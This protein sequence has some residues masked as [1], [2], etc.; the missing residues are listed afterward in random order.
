LSF[1]ILSGKFIMPT[2]DD[3]LSP[4]PAPSSGQQAK[5]A[6]TAAAAPAAAQQEEPP[7]IHLPPPR[8]PRP[9]DSEQ[10]A[11]R[12]LRLDSILVALTLLLAFLLASFPARNSDVWAHLA[13]GR[14]LVQDGFAFGS[15]PFLF[16]T[17]GQ[18]W[19][20]HSWLYD[21]LSYGIYQLLGGSGLVI[22]K[23]LLVV[24]VAELMLRLGRVGRNL[25]AP[26]VCTAVALV[27]MSPGLHLQPICVSYLGLALTVWFLDRQ[28][29]RLVPEDRTAAP[30]GAFASY[31]PLLVLFVLWVNLDVWFF[32][33]P[34]AV[35]LYWL[36]EALETRTSN[37]EVHRRHLRLLGLVLLAGLGVC[38]LNPYHV[39]GFNLIPLLAPAPELAQDP[40]FRG[41]LISPFGALSL[42]PTSLA[43]LLLVGLGAGS[44]ALAGRQVRGWRLALWLGFFL[45]SVYQAR[46]VPFFAIVAGPILALHLQEY[47]ARR[48]TMVRPARVYRWALAGRRLTVA[49]GLVLLL[50]AWQGLVQ[51]RSLPLWRWVVEPD[52]ALP[53]AADQL[54]QWRG[55]GRLAAD[56]EGFNFS[57]DV[58]NYF[59]WAAPQK[60]FADGRLAD[61]P[62]VA[63][64]HAAIRQGVEEE[65]RRRREGRG[66]DLASPDWR[67]ILR[68]HKVNHIIL[69]DPDVNR[70]NAQ[71]E[72]FLTYPAEWPLLHL[73]GHTA[74]FGWRDPARRERD[75]FVGLRF[76]LQAAAFHPTAKKKAPSH[77]P[78]RPPEVRAWWDL[79]HSP[80]PPRP[81]DTD[82]AAIY[83]QYFETLVP[84]QRINQL[85]T[86]ASCMPVGLVG[87]TDP[88]VNWTAGIL[89][90]LGQEGAARSVLHFPRPKE[91]PGR[92]DQFA[93]EWQAGFLYSQDEAPLGLPLLAVRAA[94]RGVAASPDDANNYLVLAHA[95]RRLAR[96]RERSWAQRGCPRLGELRKVQV[97]TA[98]HNVLAANPTPLQAAQAHE[99]L[100]AIN[101]Q[102]N[103]QDVALKHGQERIRHFRAAGVIPGIPPQQFEKGMAR[104]E[105]ELKEF[106][107]DVR[108]LQDEY[109]AN[110]GKLR[111]LDQARLARN[112]GLAGKALEVL[113]ASDITSFGAEGAQLQLELMLT[114]G[115]ARDAGELLLPDL[116]ERLTAYP[117]HWI[118]VQVAAAAGDYAAADRELWVVQKIFNEVPQP[119]GAP[120][121]LRA[122]FG[123][124]LAAMT[125]DGPLPVARALRRQELVLLVHA[126]RAEAEVRVLRGLLALEWGET[127]QAAEHFRAALS[128]WGDVAGQPSPSGLEFSARWVAQ[129]CLALLR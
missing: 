80:A 65:L 107:K 22:L 106:E 66:P 69:L 16:T 123:A 128:V 58:G 24:L 27:A 23:A 77:G 85:F 114:T 72:Y 118:R 8:A 11:R 3:A 34:L 117:Y 89:G 76:D 101:R 86:W 108:E 91:R 36:G 59:A 90:R 20:N 25:W 40:Y 116:K 39:R 81:L 33:G 125:L 78:S 49:A 9:L 126:L 67:E 51:A 18:T 124:V 21:L 46:A 127:E 111:P 4:P 110:V 95:Y 31:W 52:P 5:T 57:P 19:V 103:Y 1:P 50:A 99:Y 121:P 44:F 73:D 48:S 64:E 10:A 120:R 129:D 63:K 102:I 75:P 88:R 104:L 92:L 14:A 113:L 38:L 37:P 55:A 28:R 109:E 54:A 68:R 79:L 45:L 12:L 74:I 42:R 30:A 98:L 87:L 53:R 96:T 97:I 41:P 15:D 100:I 47:A 93:L 6:V 62:A 43:Y 29:R 60:T 105:Q 32:L 61:F 82:E 119:R 17:A 83:L 26:T 7:D 122:E 35:G 70:L 56:A 94:R 112:K 84:R 13:A 71:L 2:P 115:R